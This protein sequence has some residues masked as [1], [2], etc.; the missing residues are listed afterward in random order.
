MGSVE[1]H[2]TCQGVLVRGAGG[3]GHVAATVRKQRG[4]LTGFLLFIQS[5]TAAMPRTF[6]GIL[7]PPLNVSDKA[8]PPLKFPHRHTQRCVHL[9]H[10]KPVE[11][12]IKIMVPGENEM[13]DF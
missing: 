12:I 3:S 7:P 13:N 2:L 11:L 10:L 4:E 5:R 9:V 8:P 6:R 1:A